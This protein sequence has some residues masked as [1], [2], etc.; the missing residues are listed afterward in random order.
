MTWLSWERESSM[1][2][3]ILQATFLV[4]STRLNDELT[5]R[6][7]LPVERLGVAWSLLIRPAT[8]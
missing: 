8:Y 1:F 4:E 5:A 6:T 3:F 7:P 2:T